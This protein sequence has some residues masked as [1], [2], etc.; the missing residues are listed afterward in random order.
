L[1]FCGRNYTP[2]FS[3]KFPS[4][5]LAAGSVPRRW[6]AGTLQDPHHYS[7]TTLSLCRLIS[8]VLSNQL[9]LFCCSHHLGS[10]AG[11]GTN[12]AS[13]RSF[14]R[15][16]AGVWRPDARLNGM[17]ALSV[18][19]DSLFWPLSYM[20]SPANFFFRLVLNEGLLSA[21]DYYTTSSAQVEPKIQIL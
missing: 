2:V 4:L 7:T 18:S 15:M 16:A 1:V 20:Q 12:N 14:K 9:D 21:L 10:S 3:Q 5:L 11:L 8:S 6:L 17:S 13:S 19:S